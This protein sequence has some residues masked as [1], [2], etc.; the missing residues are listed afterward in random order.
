MTA[1]LLN[2]AMKANVLLDLLTGRRPAKGRPALADQAW[3]SRSDFIREPAP[4]VIRRQR[5]HEGATPSTG[6]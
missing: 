2:R 4:L 3:V 6:R 5:P 1:M